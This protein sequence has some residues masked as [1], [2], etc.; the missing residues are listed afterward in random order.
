M[1]KST[2]EEIRARFDNDVE[3]FSNL[4]IG[5]SATVDAPL[6]LDLIA[7]AAKG[8]APNAAKMLDIGCGAGN[9]CLRMRRELPGLRHFT[10]VDLSR[11]MLNR[12]IERLQASGVDDLLVLHGDVRELELGDG[13]FD[14]VTAAAA[15]HHLRTDAE[16]E[17]V[18]AKIHRAL[19]PGGWLWVSDL[20]AHADPGLHDVMWRR[21]G[22]YLEGFKGPEY[23]EHVLAYVT[24]EDTPRPLLFQVDVLRK[25]GFSEVEILHKNG[26]FG[27]YGARK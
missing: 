15:L 14:I 3:R 6:V 20:I 10:L 5:Q 24:K 22:E 4:E 19:K 17:A 11:R 13:H 9:Y 26:C 2:V 23:R 18:F 7:Q 12:A 21:Y 25:V 1:T 16:W 8:T 27:A